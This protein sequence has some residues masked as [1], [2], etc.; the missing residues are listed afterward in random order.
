MSATRPSQSTTVSATC[1]ERGM[2]V[3]NE[4]VLGDPLRPASATGLEQVA[5]CAGADELG[6][7]AALLDWFRRR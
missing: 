1:D 6:R 2:P 3:S 4:A 7:G 5:V